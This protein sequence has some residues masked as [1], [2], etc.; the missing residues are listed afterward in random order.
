LEAGV[1]NDY[2]LV[3]TPSPPIET[4]IEV[5]QRLVSSRG[6]CRGAAGAA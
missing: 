4:P 2:F 3:P 5:A 6:S 1:A